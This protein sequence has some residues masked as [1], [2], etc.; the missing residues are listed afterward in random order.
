VLGEHAEDRSDP[1][2][3]LVFGDE[4]AD[5]TGQRRL[6]GS[7]SRT[8]KDVAALRI[9]MVILGPEQPVHDVDD[10]QFEVPG[11]ALWTGYLRC[12]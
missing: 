8:K 7:L 12:L 1:E 3:V 5:R 9:S 10:T 2:A 6:C 4:R 11:N